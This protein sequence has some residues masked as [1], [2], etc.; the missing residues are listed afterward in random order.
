LRVIAS[1]MAPSQRVPLFGMFFSPLL[2][3]G[4]PLATWFPLVVW[5]IVGLVIYFGCS[6]RD[7]L[8][9]GGT[10]VSRLSAPPWI[11]SR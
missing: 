6:N 8:E 7:G 1:V 11:T 2:M 3:L 5:L 10:G 4:L 9:A